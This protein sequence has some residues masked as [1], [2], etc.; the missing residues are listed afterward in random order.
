VKVA[1][2]SMGYEVKFDV[3]TPEEVICYEK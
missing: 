3:A 1:L 2:L